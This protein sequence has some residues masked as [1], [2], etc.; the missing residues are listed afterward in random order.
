MNL[1]PKVPRGGVGPRVCQNLKQTPRVE[2]FGSPTFGG[3]TNYVDVLSV[4]IYQ[5][6][7]TNKEDET[8]RKERRA[9]I[10]TYEGG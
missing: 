10:K 5:C 1:E 8:R 7:N 3:L 6:G 2:K 9:Q 4:P